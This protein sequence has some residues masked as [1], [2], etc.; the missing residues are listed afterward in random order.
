[1]E[2]DPGSD[3]EEE[4]VLNWFTCGCPAFSTLLCVRLEARMGSCSSLLKRGA[5]VSEPEGDFLGAYGAVLM[6]ASAER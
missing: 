3:S 6:S 1:M 2:E 4:S 5:S